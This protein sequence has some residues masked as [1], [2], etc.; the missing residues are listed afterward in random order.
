MDRVMDLCGMS[1]RKIGGSTHLNVFVYDDPNHAADPESSCNHVRREIQ[2]LGVPG[3]DPIITG[4]YSRQELKDDEVSNSVIK[5]L[6]APGVPEDRRR[7]YARLLAV[8][9]DT[10]RADANVA[11]YL[12]DF[13]QK[14]SKPETTHLNYYARY[15]FDSGDIDFFPALREGLPDSGTKPVN[16]WNRLASVDVEGRSEVSWA[17]GNILG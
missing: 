1:S 11:W 9:G 4:V 13:S 17:C 8:P 6:F 3:A 10:K 15:N 5:K 16:T 7:W 2:N 14:L 12:A